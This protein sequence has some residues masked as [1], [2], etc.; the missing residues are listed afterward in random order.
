VGHAP[1]ANT[2]RK[3]TRSW[4]SGKTPSPF[5]SIASQPGVNVIVRRGWRDG[6]LFSLAPMRLVPPISVS[7]PLMIYPKLPAGSS[8][9]DCTSATMPA[10]LGQA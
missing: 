1:P 5:K 6:S 8:S 10:L 4:L 2:S 9:H 3:P 7:S